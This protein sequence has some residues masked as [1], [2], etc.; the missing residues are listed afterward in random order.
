MN[1]NVSK[2]IGKTYSSPVDKLLS[3]GDP[4]QMQDRP[5][6]L[7]M[8][9]GADQIPE[10]IRMATDEKLNNAPSDSSE[11]WAPLHAWRTLGQLCAEAAIE[12]LLGL[13]AR[14]DQ[15]QDDWVSE[16]LPEALGEI[17]PK[18]L[19]ALSA[20]LADPAHGPESR[21]AA[22]QSIVT[23]GQRHRASRDRCVHAL[24][25]QLEQFKRNSR[26]L[27]GMLISLLVDCGAAEAAPVI[28]RAFATGRV[29]TPVVG[30]WEDVQMMLGP[31]W[32]QETHGKFSL[33]TALKRIVG[34]RR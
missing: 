18:A 31:S 19:P 13:F 34:L 33:F 26:N 5:D 6:Y 25:H 17:G 3:C 28:K 21:L 14:A 22:A 12:P 24:S 16:D 27:N 32:E 20:Y 4:R 11:V 2:Q 9:F 8:G 1:G 7:A 10:L 15:Q 23:V 30:D 29:D